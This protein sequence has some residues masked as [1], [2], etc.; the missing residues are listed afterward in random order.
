[1]HDDVQGFGS[2]FNAANLAELR[3]HSDRVLATIIS[4]KL[5]SKQDVTLSGNL[6]YVNYVMDVQMKTDQGPRAGRTRW[7]VI[8][9]KMNNKWAVT[10]FHVS[11]DPTMS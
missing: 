7:T 9:R 4:A 6:A 8:F 3:E 2:S 1:M 5:A 10:H 11:R